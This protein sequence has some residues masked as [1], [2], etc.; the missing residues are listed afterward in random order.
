MK[1]IQ[2]QKQVLRDKR[3]IRV[4]KKLRG[5]SI[6]PRLCVVKTNKHIQV[7]LIDDEK[8]LTIA[9][10]STL[11]KEFQ[12]TEFNRR[13]KASAKQLGE[14]IAEKAAENNIKEAIF[15]RGYHKYHGILAELA[16]AAR[17]SGLKY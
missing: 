12:K 14:K 1:T 10:T 13:N 2:K 9:A 11:A 4:R 16:E 7:Q 6:K 17:S 8:G 15:D 3:A 5:N